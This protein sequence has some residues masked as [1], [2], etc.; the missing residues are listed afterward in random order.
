MATK[1]LYNK[2]VAIHLENELLNSQGAKVKT[3]KVRFNTV[4]EPFE[5]NTGPQGPTGPTGP[6]GADGVDGPTGET[7]PAGNPDMIVISPNGQEYLIT[8]DNNG[9]LGTSALGGGPT[10]AT[11]ATGP[12]SGFLPTG[13]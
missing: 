1:P 7:G 9:V 13:P 3:L 2:L 11:A 10:S 8:V 6:T 5:A 4:D 12:A